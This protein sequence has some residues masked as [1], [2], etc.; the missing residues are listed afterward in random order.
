MFACRSF[1]AWLYQPTLKIKRGWCK[2][3]EGSADVLV[4][5]IKEAAQLPDSCLVNRPEKEKGAVRLQ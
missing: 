1:S 5:R 4:R 2:G 3:N